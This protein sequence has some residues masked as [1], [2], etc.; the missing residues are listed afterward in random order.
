MARLMGLFGIFYN[1]VFISLFNCLCGSG[2]D[3]RK[4]VGVCW[5]LHSSTCLRINLVDLYKLY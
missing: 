5:K 3:N 4:T 2:L 1:D